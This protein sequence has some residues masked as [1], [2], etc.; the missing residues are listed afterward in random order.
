[1]MRISNAFRVAGALLAAGGLAT[2]AP[3]AFAAG[4][5]GDYVEARSASVYA[6][7]CHYNG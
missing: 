3:A 5:S 6:G 4:V 2:A 1:M 7:P